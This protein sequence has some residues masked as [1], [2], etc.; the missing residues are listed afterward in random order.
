MN[1]LIVV[2][3]LL[4]VLVT[5]AIIWQLNLSG[6]SGKDIESVKE[7]VRLENEN[8]REEMHSRCGEIERKLDRI[9][10]KLDKIIDML[11]PKLPDGLKMV[12]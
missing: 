4:I 1:K 12:P 3:V 9:E 7:T 6:V 11:T 5:G 10:G 8:L 2:L